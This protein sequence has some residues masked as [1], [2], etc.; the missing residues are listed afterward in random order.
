MA[1]VGKITLVTGAARGIGAACARAL[2]AK[3]AKV[4]LLRRLCTPLALL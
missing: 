3:G 2:G 4:R 1:F